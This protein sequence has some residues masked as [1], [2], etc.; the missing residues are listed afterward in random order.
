MGAE[1]AS[2]FAAY[3][4]GFPSAV[5]AGRALNLR[6]FIPP[7][8]G[9]KFHREG[10]VH[11]KE[12]VRGR[13]LPISA[14]CPACGQSKTR[15]QFYPPERTELWE[16]HIGA[17]A[18]QQIRTLPAGFT[19]PI[20]DC[21]LIVNLR[22]NFR[23]PKS[24]A[25]SVVHHVVKPDVDNAEKAIYDALVK[26]GVMK[27]DAMITD[28]TVVKRYAAPGHPSGCEVDLTAIQL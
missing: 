17:Q 26:T 6:L 16:E 25:K 3:P 20:A 23:K 27:D 28:H 7:I 18:M 12:R 2:L 15:V 4:E 22:F 21:R 8:F 1:Q 9:P 24:Y 11:F 14:R 19:I 5:V 10:D 13:T